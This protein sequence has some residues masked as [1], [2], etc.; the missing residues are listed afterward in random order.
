[1]F[2][3]HILRQGN[4]SLVYKFF[5]AQLSNPT[6]GD[7]VSDILEVREEVEF[8]LEL[9][10]IGAMSKQRF[11]S[12][13]RNKVKLKAFQYLI[14]KREE[15]VS[16]HSKGKELRYSELS[17]AQYLCA[18]DID[19]SID[20]KKWLYKCRIEDIDLEANRRWNN[21]DIQ[22]KNCKNT[23]MTQRHLLV[24]KYLLGKSEIVTYIPNYDDLFKED[25]EEQIYIS[26]LLKDN[27]NRMNAQTTM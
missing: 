21:G 2:L 7:W 1:M 22:C 19:M 4:Q 11:K 20:E 6:K 23:E 12:L 24:C 9:E 3:H 10:E 14:E 5:L 17:M 16:I 8:G 26:R 18:S 15:R 25:I 27:H 13:V